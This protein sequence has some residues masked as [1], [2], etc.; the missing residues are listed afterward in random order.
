[1]ITYYGT[2]EKKWSVLCDAHQDCWQVCLLKFRYLFSVS[3]LNSSH[4]WV[5]GTF[6]YSTENCTCIKIKF[7][8]FVSTFINVTLLQNK[9]TRM[10]ISK[11]SAPA[12]LLPRNK[13]L[14]WSPLPW[15]PNSRK[16]FIGKLQERVLWLGRLIWNFRT[17]SLRTLM[18]FSVNF[19]SF[20]SSQALLLTGK[21]V[22]EGKP[23]PDTGLWLQQHWHTALLTV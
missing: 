12:S 22:S 3:H 13:N 16:Y 11:D 23:N 15:R 18:Q 2:K 6:R 21:E 9:L 17:P 10:G 5:T 19:Y 4:T 7:N 8:H 20:K 1:M 14:S